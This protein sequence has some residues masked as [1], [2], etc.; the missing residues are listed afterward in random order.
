MVE[1]Q[2]EEEHKIKVLNSKKIT[3]ATL[4]KR[5][6]KLKKRLLKERI[7]TWK[8]K[9]IERDNWTCQMSG[10]KLLTRKECH[11]H[12]I[13]SELSVLRKYPELIDDINNGILLGYYTHK[14]APF[15]AHQGGFEWVL[16]FK[17][18][19]PERYEYLVNKIKEK[20]S[21]TI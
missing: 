16:W 12:H 1:E 9:V 2:K 11:P 17:E 21:N 8:L 3:K 19:F 5:E 15:S 7:E 13:I 10:K 4:E 6:R 14:A 18:K 20:N